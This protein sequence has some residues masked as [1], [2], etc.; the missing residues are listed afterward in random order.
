MVK[1]DGIFCVRQRFPVLR[2]AS[3][4]RLGRGLRNELN[5]HDEVSTLMTKSEPYNDFTPEEQPVGSKQVYHLHIGALTG[6][7]LLRIAVLVAKLAS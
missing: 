2:S 1:W 5:D 6:G 3:E 4:R 7:G